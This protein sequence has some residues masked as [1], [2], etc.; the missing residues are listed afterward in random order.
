[1]VKDR[2]PAVRRCPRRS[3]D[4]PRGTS[5]ARSPPLSRT[6]PIASP[7]L[8]MRG[9]SPDNR[10]LGAPATCGQRPLRDGG[11]GRGSPAASAGGIR[12]PV[13]EP[14]ATVLV[15]D[16]HAHQADERI[17]SDD[18]P[19]FVRRA[20]LHQP[21]HVAIRLGER[22]HAA[23]GAMSGLDLKAES[24]AGASSG[25]SRRSAGDATLMRRSAV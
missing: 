9:Y 20:R 22:R 11:S 4:R 13:S 7:P 21:A 19:G 2:I 16:A 23:W 18:G 1:M 14:A 10:A 24:T 17:L 12:H 3:A 8:L 6:P 15:V 25:R 5:H